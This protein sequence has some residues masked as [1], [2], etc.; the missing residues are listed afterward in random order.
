MAEILIIDDEENLSFSLQLALKR[1]GHRCRPAETIRSGLAAVNRQMPDL[2]LLDMQLPDGS[3]MDFLARLREDGQDIPVIVITA[4]GTVAGAVAAM[5]HGAVDYIQ[6]PLSMEEVILAID[7]CL[8]HRRIRNRLDAFQEAQRR[9]SGEIRIIGQCPQIKAVLSLAQKIAAVPSDPQGGLVTTL[10]LGETGTGKE[11]LTRY[12]HHHGLRPDRPFVQVNCTAIPETLFES[13]LF[14]HEKGSFT[15][16]KTTKKGL[17]EM[18]QEGTLFLDEIGDMPLATQAKLL[19]AIENGRFRRIGATTERMADVRVV[20]ATNSDLRHKVEQGLF[21]ADLYYR[22]K[23]F[24]VD[25]PPLRERGD[26]IFLLSDFFLR[27]CCQKLHKPIPTMPAETRELMK[28]YAW[29]GNIREL[30][31]VLQRAVL[32]NETG[33]LDPGMLGLEGGRRA[34]DSAGLAGGGSPFDF[35]REDCTL[36]AVERKLVR[37][38]LEHTGGNVSETARLL[39]LTR[40]GLRHRMDKLGL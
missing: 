32:V 23:V 11:V 7:R 3:G 27:Q 4:F 17:I 36:V 22:I 15:D 1:A 21:R 12:I 40:G 31:N 9:E 30:A 13:E 14:G 33:R 2:V 16:A 34:A 18:A 35:V 38:A 25:L 29:P 37:A 39:G 26:D 10:V 5:K 6:K 8:E 19:V 28:H 24:T 20:A